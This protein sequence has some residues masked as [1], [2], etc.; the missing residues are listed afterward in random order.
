MKQNLTYLPWLILWISAGLLFTLAWPMP[1]AMA[2]T[3]ATATQDFPFIEPQF[4]RVTGVDMPDDETITSLAQDSRGLIWIGTH[5]GLVRYDG[6]RFRKF[7]HKDGDPHSLSDDYIVALLATKE[8][9]IVVGTRSDG[10]SV[11]DPSTE[12][13]THFRNDPKNPDSLSGGMIWSMTED[14]EGGIWIAN[15]EGINHLPRSSK[16]FAHFKHNAQANSLMDDKVR[17]LLWD[18]TGRLWVGGIKGLQR[19]SKDRKTF[20]TII[21][22]RNVQ[23]LFQAQDGKLW[24]GTRDHGFGWLMPDPPAPEPHVPHWQPLNQASNTWVVGIAQPYPDQIWLSTYGGGIYVLAA[25]DGRQIHHLLHDASR[26]GSLALDTVRPM[27]QDSAAWLWVGT[28]GGGLQRIN[29]HNT[30][31]RLL[32]HS[33][34]QTKTL[35]Q[36]DIRAMLELAN[37]QIL[38]GSNNNGIDIFDRLQ[39]RI[40]DYRPGVLPDGSI[41]ALA[42]TPDGSIWIGTQK[43]G[44]L[45]QLA[46]SKHWTSLPGLP[47]LLILKLLVATDGSI[48]AGTANGVARMARPQNALGET[49]LRFELLHDTQGKPMRN[50]VFALAQDRQGRIWIGSNKGLWLHVPGQPDLINI[51]PEPNRAN[52]LISAQITGLLIDR[53]D[54]LW[55]ATD[56]GLEYM[57]SWDGKQAQFEHISA[58]LGQ[59]GK[60]LGDQL[61]EDQAGRIWTSEAI[62]EKVQSSPSPSPSPNPSSSKKGQTPTSPWRMTPL[63]KADGM[64]VGPV[65]TNAYTK[66]RDGL[67]LFGGT[68]GVAI[69][70]PTQ[71]KPYDYAPPL[72]VSELEINGKT[73]A[74]SGLAKNLS[75]LTLPPTQRTFAIEFAALDYAEPNKNRY[76]YRLEG[77]EKD[78]VNTDANHRSAA[79]GNLWPGLYTLQVRGTNRMGVW[80]PHELRIPIRILPA[81]WQ[82]WWFGIALLLSI[83]TLIAAIMQKRTHNLRQQQRILEQ[84]VQERTSELL[85]ANEELLQSVKTLRKLGHIGREITANL[86]ADTVFQSLYLYMAGLLNAPTMIIYRINSTATAL[87]AVFGRDKGHVIPTH[88]IALDS[89]TS[90]AAQAARERQELLIHFHPNTQNTLLPISPLPTLPPMHSALFAPLF[91]DDKLLG[92]MT[93]QTDTENTY[94]ERERQIFRTLSAY[95]AIAL[96][97]AATMFAL[98][99]AQG[100][101]VQQEKM[102]SLGNLVA[103][104][105]HEI[106]TPL[107]TTLVAISGA[108]SAWHTLKNALA[109]GS[110]SKSL[111]ESSTTEGIEYTALALKTANRAAEL[112]DLF[113]TIAINTDSDSNQ[114]VELELSH[115]LPELL[116][117]IRAPLT[118]KGCKLEL[119]ITP[120]LTIK[121]VP[122]ALTEALSRV[123]VNALDHAF[124][125]GRIGTLQLNAQSNTKGDGVIITIS[126][127]GHG[128]S[129]QN[130]PKVFD[131]FFTTKSGLHGHVGLGLHVA[132]NHVTQRLKGHINITSTL[133]EGSRV[134]IR[135]KN[136]SNLQKENA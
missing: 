84:Q 111:L 26:P 57:Q 73:V 17:S 11:F 43:Q 37:G 128:I 93:I 98:R 129:P 30:M 59:A 132:Y 56:K 116:G 112:I 121:L 54:H 34:K 1:P 74:P 100:Q 65:W 124:T 38:F 133:G 47:D 9:R 125:D 76:Q 36:P 27:L 62:I 19:M 72:V 15:N 89:P 55:I 28:Y 96:A 66:T 77:Y 14:Q 45:G 3:A 53:D 80:S 23:M 113:K 71:F 110:L 35:S 126:D 13:F 64:D 40:G 46:G 39:G 127:N 123:L 18:K 91:V 120:G 58:L 75:T 8:G 16:R 4:E 41:M 24:V 29:T 97:N 25:S 20:E 42:Q 87:D 63:T 107:G 68:K 7:N 105:A 109:A 52:S 119:S 21:Q 10:I 104:I 88:R 131:P 95:G 130:L 61:L 78:W 85:T 48:W 6:Y 81:W 82:T 134:E 99:K 90:H 115:Y 103:G 101:L 12:H 67:L 2:A 94:N 33:L 22:N 117:L 92:V 49:A 83:T 106:N 60:P 86:D 108:E 118:H 50:S 70:D 102:A 114:I 44:V 31:L 69:I 79:Y 32:R 5:H 135:L 136:L 51:Q 122:E